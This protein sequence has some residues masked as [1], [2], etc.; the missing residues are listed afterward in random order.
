LVFSL[1]VSHGGQHCS[2]FS[3]YAMAH[4]DR[5]TSGVA[6][7]LEDGPEAYINPAVYSRLSEHTV[8][9]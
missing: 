7:N 9:A 3:A 4:K 8:M 1:S 6:Y 2:I 5:A